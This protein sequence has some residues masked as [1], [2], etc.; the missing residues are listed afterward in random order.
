MA[1]FKNSKDAALIK[2][3]SMSLGALIKPEAEGI[4]AILDAFKQNPF[5]AEGAK[6]WLELFLYFHKEEKRKCSNNEE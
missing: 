5:A 1:V 3:A 4:P 6:N 2:N